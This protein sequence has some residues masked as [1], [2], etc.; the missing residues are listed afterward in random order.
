MVTVP[1]RTDHEKMHTAPHI[2]HG[3]WDTR[4]MNVDEIVV[5]DSTADH[6]PKAMR[7]EI[8]TPKVFKEEQLRVQLKV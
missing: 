2:D 6:E 5:T 4:D 1:Y 8:R 3:A 7:P